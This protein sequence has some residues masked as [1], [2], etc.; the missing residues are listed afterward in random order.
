GPALVSAGIVTAA[1]A[2]GAQAL[3]RDVLTGF[4]FLFE[5]T[6]DVGNAVEVTTTNGTIV[7]TVESVGL[8]T[9]RIVDSR[10]RNVT[11]PNGSIVYVTNAS[12]F[13]NRADVSISLPLKA[14][15]DVMRAKIVAIAAEEM[16]RFGAG[17]EGAWV[18]IEGV[19]PDSITFRIEFHAADQ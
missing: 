2:F 15:V 3:V 18:S 14:G 11:V 7:G 5:D 9:T 10:G 6:Y 16:K 19:S 4:F 12:R 13:P 1:L 8:R 17:A